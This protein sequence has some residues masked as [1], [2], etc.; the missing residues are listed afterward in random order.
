MAAASESSCMAVAWQLSWAGAGLPSPHMLMLNMGVREGVANAAAAT[1]HR[2]LHWHRLVLPT[3][4]RARLVL[5]C[6]RER[7]RRR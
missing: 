6:Q 5:H 3:A 4:H 7:E 1:V 2:P